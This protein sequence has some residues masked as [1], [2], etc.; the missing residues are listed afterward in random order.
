[1]Y[2]IKGS[3]PREALSNKPKW[4]TD[5]PRCVCKNEFNQQR[6][7]EVGNYHRTI[8]FAT[9]TRSQ[10]P[11]KTPATSP[12]LGERKTP[13]TSEVSLNSLV[14]VPPTE[15]RERAAAHTM[16]AYEFTQQPAAPPHTFLTATADLHKAGNTR[17]NKRWETRSR[18]SKA[19]PP[20]PVIF[21]DISW[22]LMHSDVQ[23]V[24]RKEKCSEAELH[25]VKIKMISVEINTHLYH[26]PLSLLSSGRFKLCVLASQTLKSKLG[27]DL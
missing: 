26:F 3:G 16:A 12:H 19:A 14:F 10:K 7:P 5:F 2:Q 13:G 4:L 24:V 23:N 27:V 25:K 11:G 18:Q 17:G 9:H 8:F 20:R 22:Q 6:T 21:K 15:K 1:M